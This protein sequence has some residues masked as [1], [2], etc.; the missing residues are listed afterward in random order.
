MVLN[1]GKIRPMTSTG[2]E[3]LFFWCRFRSCLDIL[4]AAS[5]RCRH[6]GGACRLVEILGMFRTG[7]PKSSSGGCAER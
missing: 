3:Q 7:R 2:W 6:I 1:F 5:Y 4:L